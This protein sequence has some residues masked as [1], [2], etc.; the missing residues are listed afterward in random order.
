MKFKAIN[1]KKDF[2]IFYLSQVFL[3]RPLS[4]SSVDPNSKFYIYDFTKIFKVK[5][6]LINHK[7]I[8]NE[9]KTK[10]LNGK[11]LIEYKEYDFIYN[12]FEKIDRKKINHILDIANSKLNYY[13]KFLIKTI[14]KSDLDKEVIVSFIQSPLDKAYT[15]PDAFTSKVLK[16][17][18]FLGYDNNLS[19]NDKEKVNYYILVIFHEFTH[20]FINNNLRFHKVLKDIWEKDYKHIPANQFRLG[21]EEII[22]S[23]FVFPIYGAGVGISILKYKEN[24]EGQAELIKNRSYFKLLYEF[25]NK[26]NNSKSKNKLEKYLP[27]LIKKLIDGGM[28][29]K[30]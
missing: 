23:A 28:F 12:Y 4:K 17:K 22:V 8:D 21:L 1:T 10:L 29:A 6:S 18:L 3:K 5:K 16:N 11:D 26:L 2:F 30:D 7:V 19:L 20:I 27:I 25:L 15:S 13:F 24:K 14:G 9:S